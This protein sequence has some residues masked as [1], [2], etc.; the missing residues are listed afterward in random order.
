VEVREYVRTLHKHWQL[1]LLCTLLG[2][3]AGA[4]FVLHAPKKY[5]SR[6]QLFVSTSAADTDP[7][8]IFQGG[9]FSE[10]RV[11]SYADMVG[12]PL[13]SAK[14]ADLIGDGLTAKTVQREV[15]ASAPSNTVL[16][17]VTVIDRSARRAQQIADDIGK[18]FPG[19]VDQIE[20]TS[21][22]GQSPVKVSVV[23]PATFSSSPT[24]PKAVL[25]V[26]LGLIVGLFLGLGTAMLREALDNT[27]K[28]PDDVQ[29]IA[30][31]PALG[32]VPYD[33]DAKKHPLISNRDMHGSRAE[34]FRQLRTNLQFVDVDAPVRSIVVTSSVPGE[35]KTTTVCNL[36][37]AV[38]HSGLRVLLVEADLRRPRVGGYL[39]I[40]DKVGLTSVLI[41]AA[42]VD[43]A[44]QSWGP[45]DLLDV[46]PAGP[47]PPNPSELLGSRGMADLLHSLEDR[48]DLVLLDSPPL[49][50]VTDAAVIAPET[51]GA[52]IVVHYGTTRTE[53]L[54]R[55]AGALTSVGA[56]TLGAVINFAPRRGPDA[57]Y[58]GY[59]YGYVNGSKP[60]ASPA[61]AYARAVSR[62]AASTSNGVTPAHTPPQAEPAPPSAEP[63]PPPVPTWVATP[64]AVTEPTEDQPL[65]P[66]PPLWSPP[67]RPSWP[68][69]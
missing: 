2:I 29:E 68:D 67:E 19:I 10:A 13:V 65:D 45:D 24:A 37:I 43:D 66:Q 11:Q 54:R 49:L 50:P 42:S 55:T 23:A 9:Q 59:S 46:L 15:S 7:T 20:V 28:L 52:L 60:A 1:I 48:Y 16:L 32:L 30:E 3:A 21:S 36:A 6:T 61:P 33:P 18:V 47:K 40:E 62:A 35:G 31:T 12:G 44:I 41:G 64:A 8:A 38:A 69:S 14:V 51:T 53:Q 22:G 27:V 25:D 26:G 5:E 63:A 56:R 17:N 4:L 57:Y 39:G 34:A 58:Y